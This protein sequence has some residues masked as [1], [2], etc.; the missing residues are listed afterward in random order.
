GVESTRRQPTATHPLRAEV[1][2]PVRRPSSARC[3]P[4]V[5]HRHPSDGGIAA[6]RHGGMAG[7]PGSHIYRL[8]A[9]NYR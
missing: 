9:G 3:E 5:H 1:P 2:D 4:T 8:L 6:W 7:W